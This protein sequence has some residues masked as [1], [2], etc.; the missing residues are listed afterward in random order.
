MLEG[1]YKVISPDNS[2]GLARSFPVWNP[3][4]QEVRQACQNTSS[5][6]QGIDTQRSCL[7][8]QWII[9]ENMNIKHM[10]A[11]IE[12]S[13]HQSNIED[14]SQQCV[15]DTTIINTYKQ[16][17]QKHY[18]SVHQ[19]ATMHDGDNHYHH[20]QSADPEVLS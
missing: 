7:N 13:S 4:L 10:G 15:M 14:Q 9:N 16:Q 11:C 19:N 3:T 6:D 5:Q 20:I 12:K 1:M 8:D 18:H 2:R 17:S